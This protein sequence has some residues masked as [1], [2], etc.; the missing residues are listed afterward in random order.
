ME[1]EEVRVQG[2]VWSASRPCLS[3]S[4]RAPMFTW[5]RRQLIE[6]KRD[7]R[8]RGRGGDRGQG[9]GRGEEKRKLSG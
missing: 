3:I 1:R 9:T 7:K 6:R 8:G 2:G 5:L 4:S